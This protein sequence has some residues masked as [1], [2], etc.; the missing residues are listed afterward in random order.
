M[1][2]M[3]IAENIRILREEHGLTQAELGAIAGVSDKA[4]STWENGTAYPR[5][6][7]V[8]KMARYFHVQKTQI[9]GD[10]EERRMARHQERLLAY[11]EKFSALID[12][13]SQLDETDRAKLEERAAILLES[14]K[15]KKGEN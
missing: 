6:G 2:E 11:Y 9:T 3:G 10:E 5:V 8:E 4:V 1:Y 12:L 7:A 13:A 14:E 15:Y